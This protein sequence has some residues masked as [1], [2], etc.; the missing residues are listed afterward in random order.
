MESDWA[1]LPSENL[2]QIFESCT[3]RE[4]KHLALVCKNWCYEAHYYLK[5]K[6]WLCIDRIQHANLLG[7]RRFE[8]IKIPHLC[9]IYLDDTLNIIKCLR[10]RKNKIREAH[11]VYEDY[12][13]MV[14]VLSHIGSDLHS[15]N[16][17]A[18]DFDWIY[19]QGLGDV[20]LQ[21]LTLVRNLSVNGFSKHFEKLSRC[22]GNLRT[23][24][25]DGSSSKISLETSKTLVKGNPL[26]EDLNLN[27]I[28]EDGVEA[29]FLHS[30]SHL[31][32]LKINDSGVAKSFLK[33][34][35]NLEQLS[36]FEETLT[37]D[38]L[39]RIRRNFT[40]MKNLRI[41]TIEMFHTPQR[42]T[43]DG[44]KTIWEME[45]LEKLSLDTFNFKMKVWDECCFRSVN[46][47]L[48]SLSLT[49]I[50]LSDEFMIKCTDSTPNIEQFTANIL[51][52][53]ISFRFIQE[54]ATNWVKLKKLNIF[55]THQIEFKK[56]LLKYDPSQTPAFE[57]LV[58]FRLHSDLVDLSLN[59]FKY[60]KMP[61]LKYLT[62]D[63]QFYMHAERNGT[64]E[65]SNKIIPLI[66]KNSPLIEKL[67]IKYGIH[68]SPKTISTICKSLTHLKVI[69]LDK[70]ANLPLL[71]V[72]NILKYSKSIQLINMLYF[73]DIRLLRD[74]G[75]IQNF[76]KKFCESLSP[77]LRPGL[78]FLYMIFSLDGME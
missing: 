39:F 19:D 66:V 7:S 54:M 22:F 16:L 55:I 37:N 68:I 64:K 50:M 2:L 77:P 21:N 10:D 70:C 1:G 45:S 24:H 13:D 67:M 40:K 4:V 78:Y 58:S 11:I 71:T 17:V 46:E 44:L 60:F 49:N 69:T 48:T 20:I 12:H 76:I 36:M 65:K 52:Y 75:K 5:D 57:K 33:K 63:L 35:M 61:N 74:C 42:F 43:K 26:L 8:N 41:T 3:S 25:L 18:L 23:L 53:E 29:D 9:G 38:D 15:L 59:F 32:K 14:K 31:K 27:N 73:K 6:V 51:N 34:G 47:N 28:F 56:E 30:L 62:M 72:Q